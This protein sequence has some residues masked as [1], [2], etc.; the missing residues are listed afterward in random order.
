MYGNYVYDCE[1]LKSQHP[2][3]Y[4]IILEQ[5]DQCLDRY[6]YGMIGPESLPQVKLHSHTTRALEM[7]SQPIAK[8]QVPE[9]YLNF[10]G[11]SF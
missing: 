7:M 10:S 4:Q 11:D 3:G 9:Q 1:S 5:K 8:L 6:I 2:A